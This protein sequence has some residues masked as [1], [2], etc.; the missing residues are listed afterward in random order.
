MEKIKSF[1]T[2]SKMF[3][4]LTSGSSGADSGILELFLNDL[5]S[6]YFRMVSYIDGYDDVV[7]DIKKIQNEE[8]TKKGLALAEIITDELPQKVQNEQLKA[9]L[10]KGEFKQAV[11]IIGAAFEEVAKSI[12]ED[13]A[14]AAGKKISDLC[15]DK[16]QLLIKSFKEKKTGSVSESISDIRS[17]NSDLLLEKKDRFKD[18]RDSLLVDVNTQMANLKPQI[19]NALSD[20]FISKIKPLY[21]K[22][23]VLK[24]ELE[25][26]EKWQGMKRKEI[27]DRLSKI[28]AE[29]QEVYQANSDATFNELVMMGL[30]KTTQSKVQKAMEQINGI[31]NSASEV[32]SQ[33]I[34]D[35]KSSQAAKEA[36]GKKET[37][38]KVTA[39]EIPS[40]VDKKENLSKKGP[41]FKRIQEIQEMINK[42]LPDSDKLPKADG[43]YGPKTEKAVEMV[44]K[45]LNLLNPKIPVTG[46]K[47]TPLFIETLDTMI[48]EKGIEEIRDRFT[49]K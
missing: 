3:E 17:R 45:I 26:D 24:K 6:V 22:L 38:R 32:L 49:K 25:N 12:G 9:Q 18:E 10:S 23:E 13:E 42:V 5:F 21:Q 7:A 19:D 35:Q 15:Y 44:S 31:L 39:K 2:F 14:K 1:H 47:M 16:I 20:R 27:L 43:L 30:E 33:Q 34:E 36:E 40:G 11:N 8:F 28:P 4:N 37:G 29:I 48:K 46:K 41:N